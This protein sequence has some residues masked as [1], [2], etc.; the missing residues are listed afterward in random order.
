MPRMLIIGPPGSGKGTQAEQLSQ[1]LGIVP[2][3]TGEI[4]RSNIGAKTALGRQA[5]K[6]VDKGDFVPDEIT[7]EMVMERLRRT[8]SQQGFLLDGYPRTMEQVDTFD[9]FLAKSG[10][11]LNMAI[12]LQVN[13]EELVQRLVERGKQSNRSDDNESVIRRRIRLYEQQTRPIISIYADRNI[14]LQI[15]GIGGP[16]EVTERVLSAMEEFLSASGQIKTKS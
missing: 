10:C 4:F 16:R 9:A 2:I 12:E 11:S 8:D 5:K 14:L 15:N 6:H 3:S 1:H 13:A 7:N